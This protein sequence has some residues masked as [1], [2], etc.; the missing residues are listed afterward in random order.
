MATTKSKVASAA[1]VRRDGSII[2]DQDVVNGNAANQGAAAEYSFPPIGSYAAAAAAQNAQLTQP[3]APDEVA[4]EVFHQNPNESR[5]LTRDRI[6]SFLNQYGPSGFNTMSN[7]EISLLTTMAIAVGQ[8]GVSSGE[9]ANKLM[10]FMK[11]H[12]STVANR[13]GLIV[14][15]DGNGNPVASGGDTDGYSP[16]SQYGNGPSESGN[17]TGDPVGASPLGHPPSVVTLIKEAFIDQSTNGPDEG[18]QPPE[19]Q[20]GNGAQDGESVV[21]FE[22]TGIQ[23]EKG[24]QESLSESEGGD[25]TVQVD[26]RGLRERFR[27][28]AAYRDAFASW[29]SSQAIR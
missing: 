13:S 2:G 8:G 5:G 12:A 29:S 17:G 24:A 18:N 15:T 3:N 7:Q 6:S 23:N 14:D 19:D 9:D 4:A 21:K 10:T 22:G 26:T 25:A 11:I 28:S 1:E 20:T 16:V 27:S